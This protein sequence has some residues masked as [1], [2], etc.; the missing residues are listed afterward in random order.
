[1]YVLKTATK[2]VTFYSHIAH[3]V[4]VIHS[5]VAENSTP[6]VRHAAY[7]PDVIGLK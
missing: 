2:N 3:S 6:L 4:N 1:M 5:H 7:Y